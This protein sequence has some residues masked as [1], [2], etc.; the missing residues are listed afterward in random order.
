MAALARKLARKLVGSAQEDEASKRGHGRHREAASLAR[1]SIELAPDDFRERMAHLRMAVDLEKRVNGRNESVA[2]SVAISMSLLRLLIEPRHELAK[3]KTGVPAK[4]IMREDLCWNKLTGLDEKAV[5]ADLREALCAARELIWKKRAARWESDQQSDGEVSQM[6]RSVP[7]ALQSL[8]KAHKRLGSFF[9]K[10]KPEGKHVATSAYHFGQALELLDP[11]HMDPTYQLRS[12]P[13]LARI[14]SE[15]R[16][17]I[18]TLQQDDSVDRCPPEYVIG[19]YSTFAG[20]FDD[21]LVNRLQYQTPTKMRSLVDAHL[22]SS[23]RRFERCL[24]LGCGTGL[25][26]LAFRNLTDHLSGVDLSPP[27]ID[28][29]AERGC[30]DSLAIGDVESALSIDGDAGLYDLVLAC[31]VLVYIG[32]LL[33]TLSA[34]SSQLRR[35][36][37]I[38]C[39][40][41]E[42]LPEGDRGYQLQPCAR[43][44]HTRQY[45]RETADK[46]GFQ[47][48]TMEKSVLRKNVG[49]DVIGTLAILTLK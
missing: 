15:A 18:G 22:G 12:Q 29:A 16:F 7:D 14:A 34:V 44:A 8:V 32:N 24:D 13:E 23:E 21:Q 31:D 43:Y 28:K 26:G 33:R 3:G 42:L 10:L 17:W 5:Y 45:V 1:G 4:R 35:D 40:S 27:M 47:V 46:A 2:S 30:Y 41:T 38:F 6:F 19:L 20:K 48:E 9:R 39:F 37:G 11:P 49:K 25:S 36:R